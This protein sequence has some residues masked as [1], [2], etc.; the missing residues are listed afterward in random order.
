MWK[1]VKPAL[2]TLS[3][4]LNLAF[5][6][7]WAR[8]AWPRHSGCRGRCRHREA[9]SSI[10]SPLHRELDVSEE[11][12]RQIEPRLEEFRDSAGEVCRGI[13]KLRQE[14]LALLAAAEVDRTAVETKQGEILAGKRKMQGLVVDH[15]LAEKEVLTVKQQELLFSRIRQSACCPGHGPLIKLDQG[16]RAGLGKAL[17]ESV[18]ENKD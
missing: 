2:I 3:V 9:E 18:D 13:R 8:Q 16:A 11:Q 7:M 1:T 10:A 6:A 17:R 15:L 12:W 5:V 14:L 4:A